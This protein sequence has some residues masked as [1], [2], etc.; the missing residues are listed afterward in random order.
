M[1]PPARHSSRVGQR[2]Q[3]A[4]G[5]AADLAAISLSPGSAQAYVV[6]VGG[7]QYDV[8][9][10]TGSADA[11]AVK[12]NTTANGGMMPWYGNQSLAIDFAL[13]VQGFFVNRTVYATNYTFNLDP[14]VDDNMAGIFWDTQY[15]TQPTPVPCLDCFTG[16]STGGAF[17]EKY[18]VATEVPPVPAPL[19]LFGAAAAFGFSRQLRKRIKSAPAAVAT[20]LPLA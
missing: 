14:N 2:L 16:G 10:F 19:P 4:L 7:T 15:G 1:H 18:A 5:A 17:H 6:T 20:S 13:A 8:T 11:N 12:F 3:L 9:N